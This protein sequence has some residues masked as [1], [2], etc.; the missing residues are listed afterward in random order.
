MISENVLQLSLIEYD[1]RFICIIGI[2]F[3]NLPRE[4]FM[5]QIGGEIP[6]RI[7]QDEWINRWM[8]E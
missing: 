8:K 5:I 1:L 3:L 2:N 7:V 4:R 6:T